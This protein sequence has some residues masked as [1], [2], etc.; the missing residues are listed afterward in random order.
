MYDWAVSL[1]LQITGLT[2]SAKL[3]KG[4]T[5]QRDV[6]PQDGYIRYNTDLGT[7]EG[8]KNGSWGSIGGGAV[9]GGT[10]TWGLEVDQVV[11][12]DWT[13][14]AGAYI[15]GVSVTSNTFTLANHNFVVGSKIHFTSQ[16][17]GMSTDTVYY[18]KTVPTTDTW[19][20]STTLNG[21]QVTGI[22]NATGI[23]VAK[24]K[25]A[26]TGAS[27]D[28]AD[29]VTVTIPNGTYLTLAG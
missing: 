21:T 14:G 23:S 4:T 25:N 24:M 7:F 15:G 19:T 16:P 17:A 26:I 22:T 9:G 6:T 20:I 13:V 8:Y 10:D 12:Q 27:L 18:V 11:T 2:A 5:A 1:F 28:I 29:G 3:P